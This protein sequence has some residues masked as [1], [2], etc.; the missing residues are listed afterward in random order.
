MSKKGEYKEFTF[1]YNQNEKK[2]YRHNIFNTT[3]EKMVTKKEFNLLLS[4]PEFINYVSALNLALTQKKIIEFNLLGKNLT[5]NI[6]KEVL[7]QIGIK[8]V[9]TKSRIQIGIINI[10]KSLFSM[11]ILNYDNDLGVAIGIVNKG[12]L[13]GLN[14]A[15]VNKST[16][17]NDVKGINIALIN[18]A[19]IS[20]GSLECYGYTRYEYEASG[21]LIGFNVALFNRSNGDIK[22]CS[23]A[24]SNST[25]TGHFS[26]SRIG[27]GTRYGDITGASFSLSNSSAGKLTGLK[28]SLLN[29]CSGDICG[30]TIGIINRSS[31]DY[32]K[33][34][35]VGL[36]INSAKWIDGFAIGV[37]SQTKYDGHKWFI[38]NK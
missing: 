1:E 24:L 17:L 21:D 18:H 33:G 4:D 19:S 27:V 20:K 3:T 22:G 34:T 28:M 37:Y 32:I 13:H 35:A 5:S 8:N 14:I 38:F 29:I 31:D 9:A 26:V 12:S 16:P 23:I 7:L 2:L 6:N 10:G 25:S 36:F 15:L 11:G 30:F